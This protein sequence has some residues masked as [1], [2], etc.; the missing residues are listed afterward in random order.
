MSARLESSIAELEARMADLLMVNRA[1]LSVLHAERDA[2]APEGARRQRVFGVLEVPAAENSAATMAMPAADCRNRWDV[3][4]ADHK[5][6]DRALTDDAAYRK[7]R[8]RARRRWRRVGGLF[9]GVSDRVRGVSAIDHNA[10]VQTCAI[11]ISE[12]PAS[13]VIEFIGRRR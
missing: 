11:E 3:V 9:A 10:E 1:V 6:C 4:G 5:S 12:A 8:R 2:E 7:L 13:T